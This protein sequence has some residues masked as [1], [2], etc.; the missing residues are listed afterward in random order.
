M[1]WTER[2]VYML[3]IV[4]IL[5]GFV[6]I[7]GGLI[8]LFES[9]REESVGELLVMTGI[10]GVVP[11][12]AGFMMCR[13]MRAKARYRR[14]ELIERQIPQLA[15]DNQGQLTISDVSMHLSVPSTKAKAILDQCHLNH[16]A[17]LQISD[18]GVVIYQFRML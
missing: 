14:D 10:L 3:G 15:K 4:V 2:L 16:L 1:R 18:T 6:M 8:N 13:R 7:A 11:V 5:F 9:P 17:D 12:A